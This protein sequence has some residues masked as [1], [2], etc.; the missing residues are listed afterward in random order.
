MQHRLT[1]EHER[2]RLS[3]TFASPTAY[4]SPPTAYETPPTV[5]EVPPTAYK[6]PLAAYKIPPTAYEI[7]PTAYEIPVPGLLHV[8]CRIG[9]LPNLSDKLG[10]SLHMGT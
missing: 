9:H 4:E 1:L 7:P 6:I 3:A 10:D 2:I 8:R 5:Y